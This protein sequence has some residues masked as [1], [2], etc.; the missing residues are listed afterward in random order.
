MH[1]SSYIYVQLSSGNRDLSFGL[2]F[3]LLS[4]FLFVRS[5]GSGKTVQI[6]MLVCAFATRR[7]IK[8]Q[9]SGAGPY[10]YFA[11]K[12]FEPDKMRFYRKCS[13][14]SNTFLFLLLNKMLV[15]RAGIHKLLVRIANMEDPDQTAFSEAV[16]SG[17]ALFGYAFLAGN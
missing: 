9:N 10:F 4:Y 5:K 6:H 13:K 11:W 2:S 16:W 15:I 3:L 12:T 17:S 14:I 8:Y 7:C 1:N